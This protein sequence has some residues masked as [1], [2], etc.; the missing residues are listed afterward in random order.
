MNSLIVKFLG[1]K[2]YNIPDT[3]IYEII[4]GWKEWYK[5][6]VDFH[7]YKDNYGKTRQMY[8]LGMAKRL[9]ED[10]ASIKMK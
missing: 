5:N 7:T 10:W 3:N 9:S 8:S 6:K 2:G 4:E 1:E